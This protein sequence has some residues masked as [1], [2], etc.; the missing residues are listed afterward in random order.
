[1]HAETERGPTTGSERKPLNSRMYISSTGTR[2]F[3]S[4]QSS[5]V[6]YLRI[7]C[8]R[9]PGLRRGKHFEVANCN[10]SIEFSERSDLA[11]GKPL[12]VFVLLWFCTTAL[13]G[14]ETRD[15]VT[16]LDGCLAQARKSVDEAG[17]SVD[18]RCD[19]GR[20]V[21]VAAIPAGELCADELRRVGVPDAAI[22]TLRSRRD[23][24]PRWCTIEAP[25]EAYDKGLHDRDKQLVATVVC[26]GSR[27]LIQRLSA[28]Q[29]SV[30]LI[31]LTRIDGRVTLVSLG[32]SG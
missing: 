6:L 21:L 32:T 19:L 3:T 13:A 2:G 27:V 17:G 10:M 9:R 22:A 16:L 29:S 18:L 31:S 24:R 15:P 4:Q 8:A 26:S 25:P 1:M 30:L 14:C 12:I 28:V 5:T 7:P 11:L 20:D 23:S